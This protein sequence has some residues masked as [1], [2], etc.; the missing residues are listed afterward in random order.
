MCLEPWWFQL[1]P[2]E[3]VL[4]LNQ[5][6]HVPEFLPHY[7]GIGIGDGPEMIL[8]GKEDNVYCP[9]YIVPLSTLAESDVTQVAYDMEMFAMSLGHSERI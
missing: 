1:S 9:V 8:I 2:A 5:R 6:F 3:E 7:F 4:P